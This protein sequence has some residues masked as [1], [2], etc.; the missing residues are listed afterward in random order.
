[1]VYLQPLM[2][3]VAFGVFFPQFVLVPIMQRALNRRVSVRI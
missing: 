2:A 3:L 1:M